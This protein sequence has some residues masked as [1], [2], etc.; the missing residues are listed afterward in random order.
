[1]NRD[2]APNPSIERTATGKPAPA[3]HVKR[4][5]RRI[6]RTEMLDER[7]DVWAAVRGKVEWARGEGSAPGE[8][9]H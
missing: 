4:W 5:P 1:M 8:S 2:R 7:K 9:R 6:R 3:A